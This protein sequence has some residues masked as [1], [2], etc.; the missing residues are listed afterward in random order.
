ML[1]LCVYLYFGEHTPSLSS[2]AAFTIEGRPCFSRN[3]MTIYQTCRSHDSQVKS[4]RIVGLW[5]IGVQYTY[6]RTK[7]HAHMS[8]IER[9]LVIFFCLSSSSLSIISISLLT[10]S[11]T[12]YYFPSFF[13]SFSSVP[14]DRLQGILSSSVGI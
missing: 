3:L 13:S 10:Q 12:V 5:K 4:N 14:A 7:T 11:S 6:L 9:Q 2:Q 1:I 8:Q